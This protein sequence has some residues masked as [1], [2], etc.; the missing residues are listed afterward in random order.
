MH[1]IRRLRRNTPR[2][3][4]K[5][6]A[7]RPP[8]PARGEVR[9]KPNGFAPGRASR[10]AS[11][12]RCAH[13]TRERE[14]THP[15]R[16]RRIEQMGFLSRA[17]SVALAAALLAPA[18]FA[19][20]WQWTDAE[21]VV[22]YT[23]NPDRVPQSQRG[24]LLKVEQGMVLPAPSPSKPPVMYAPPE[25]IPFGAD[26]FEAPEPART[27]ESPELPERARTLES[28]E[29]PQADPS[30]APEPARPPEVPERPEAEPPTTFAPRDAPSEAPA[31]RAA[32]GDAPEPPPA[33][34]PLSEAERAR[35]AQL[36]EQIAADQE[37][38]KE[39]ISRES[40][41]GDDPLRES[42]E[43][44][45]IARRLPAL[46]TE[47]RALEGVPERRGGRTATQP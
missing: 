38:L 46:Q 1:R 17:A 35:R 16:S 28:P 20:V 47:L 27:L 2:H 4:R 21:G 32:P 8:R 18:A 15:G 25:E 34:R 29:L 6:R 7:S 37:A 36:E 39:L 41:E 40:T 44:R 22:R 12:T 30:A 43:L 23:P 19:E 42:P 45:E 26:P 24:S 33:P 31:P 13:Y 5:R 10:G 3:L 11:V 9:D 14:L